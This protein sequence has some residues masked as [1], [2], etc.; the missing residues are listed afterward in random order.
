MGTH[1]TAIKPY[2]AN[3]DLVVAAAYDFTGI[4]VFGC[5]LWNNWLMIRF[6]LDYLSPKEF[7]R[8]FVFQRS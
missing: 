2:G 7:L 8:G 3:G 5:L 1:F 6:R 4:M